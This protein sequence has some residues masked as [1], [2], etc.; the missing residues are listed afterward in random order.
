MRKLRFWAII[1]IVVNAINLF[2]GLASPF[3][4]AEGGELWAW[5][6]LGL[7]RI[8]V[9]TLGILASVWI[10][11]RKVAGLSLARRQVWFYA[12]TE[13]LATVI[14]LMFEPQENS[15]YQVV[16][17]FII[18]VFASQLSRLFNSEESRSYCHNPE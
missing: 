17:I 1:G 16:G 12:L 10:L 13:A 6:G 4:D 8:A 15:R 9:A 14:Y 7:V 18:L 11:Q 5:I 2:I 3:I